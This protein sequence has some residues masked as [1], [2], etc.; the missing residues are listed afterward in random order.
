MM[1]G[2]KDEVVCQYEK[3]SRSRNKLKLK[4]GNFF[5]HNDGVM[6]LNGKEFVFNNLIG[7]ADW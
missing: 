2:A 1:T 3:I 7:E 5:H 4:V 6:N